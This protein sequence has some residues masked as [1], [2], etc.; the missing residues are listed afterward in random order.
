MVLTCAILDSDL[1][2]YQIL[3][4]YILKTKDLGFI[5]LSFD[6]LIAL[7]EIKKIR[8]PTVVFLNA[9]CPKMMGLKYSREFMKYAVVVATSLFSKYAVDAF[10]KDVADYLLRP[11]K[12]DRFLQCIKKTKNEFIIKRQQQLEAESFFVKNGVR[13]RLINIKVSEIIY[14]EAA[15]HYIQIYLEKEKIIV[16]LT[17]SEIIERLS[18]MGFSRI[19]KSF[20]I[21]NKRLKI[22]DYGQVTL[23]NKITL[24]LGRAY[25]E[26]FL[27]NLNA[28]LLM[29][30]YD[31]TSE[32]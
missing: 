4:N 22:L 14:I 23:D 16:Y 15:E 31:I 17:I 8:V 21:N 30:K 2:S 24:P 9:D 20:I 5:E 26:S 10:E 11:I 1:D 27:K 6:P 32:H 3:K 28:L 25:K 19:H 13:G 7:K 12:Y 18:D 29:S